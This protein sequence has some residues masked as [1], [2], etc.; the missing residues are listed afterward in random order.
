MVDCAVLIALDYEE[1][2]M[3]IGKTKRFILSKNLLLAAMAIP[4]PCP[5]MLDV[6]FWCH[7]YLYNYLLAASFEVIIKIATNI[8]QVSYHSLSEEWTQFLALF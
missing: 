1:S 2:D 7:L 6:N 5:W 3:L 8:D 4:I